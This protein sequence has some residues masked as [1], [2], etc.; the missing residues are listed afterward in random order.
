MATQGR[1]ERAESSTELIAG[2]DIGRLAHYAVHGAAT[3]PPTV[4]PACH[5]RPIR[6]FPGTIHNRTVCVRVS[7][8]LAESK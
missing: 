4:P 8:S 2:I 6:A 1:A 5:D 7:M 3:V